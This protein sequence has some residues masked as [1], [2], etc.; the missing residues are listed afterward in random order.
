[1]IGAPKISCSPFVSSCVGRIPAAERDGQVFARSPHGKAAEHARGRLALQRIARKDRL[2]LHVYFI[3]E[4]T[5][6]MN[7][8]LSPSILPSVISSSGC[9]N[10]GAFETPIRIALERDD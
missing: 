8:T 1:M 3:G 10:V 9:S 4:V 6:I 2:N 5:F 7:V